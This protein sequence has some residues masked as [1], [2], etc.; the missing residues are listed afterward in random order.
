MNFFQNIRILKSDLQFSPR[1]MDALLPICPVST[2]VDRAFTL[3]GNAVHMFAGYYHVEP[4]VLVRNTDRPL[5]WFAE[6]HSCS[7]DATLNSHPWKGMKLDPGEIN[8]K[9]A[10]LQNGA[11]AAGWIEPGSWALLGKRESESARERIQSAAI[12]TLMHLDGFFSC[13]ANRRPGNGTAFIAVAYEAF[14]C[15]VQDAQAILGCDAQKRDRSPDES[16][17]KTVVPEPSRR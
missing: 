1:L 7:Y 6:Y 8:A 16:L 4:A 15:A 9:A 10:E 12:E 3:V 2:A 5:P 11:E 13:V 17:A 14:S